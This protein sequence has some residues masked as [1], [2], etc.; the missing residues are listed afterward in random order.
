M[1]DVETDYYLLN[2]Q[3]MDEILRTSESLEPTWPCSTI[4]Q[5]EIAQ[6]RKA[7]KFNSLHQC[8]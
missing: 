2:E 3:K 1:P 7:K 6:V 5:K 8:P 4:A